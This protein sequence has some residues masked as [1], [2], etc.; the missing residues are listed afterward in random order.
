MKLKRKRNQNAPAR[1]RHAIVETLETRTFLSV[2]ASTNVLVFNASIPGYSGGGVA[3]PAETVTLTNTGS[4]AIIFSGGISVVADPSD[5][6]N[7][8]AQFAITNAG[9]LPG[10]LGA[11]QS[12]TVSVD[13]TASVANTIQKALLQIV[14]NDPANPD[15]LISLRGLGT[16]GFFGTAEPS[17]VNILRASNI[18]TIVGAGPNDSDASNSQYPEVPDTSSQEVPLQRLVKAGPGPVTIT[19]LASFNASNPTTVVFGYYTPGDPTDTTQLFTIAQADAQTVNP[20]LLGATSFDPGSGE[21]GLYATFPGVATGTSQPDTHYSEDP[22]NTLDTQYPRKFRFFPLKNADGSTVPNAY[23][24]AAEDYNS[25]TYNS[26]INFLGIIRNVA[27][28]PGAPS[29]AVLGLENLDLVPSTTQM[30]FNR[31]QNTNPTDP[32]GFVDTVHDTN[33]LEIINTGN[34]P[35]VISSVTLSD[36]TNWQITTPVAPNTTV[37]ANGGTLDITIKFI[38]TTDPPHTDN[39]TNDSQPANGLTVQQA[40]GVWDAT[41][42]IAANDLARPTRTVDLAGYWQN[43]S[44]N[45]NEPGLQTIVNRL[46]GYTTTI[47]SDYQP[48]FPA[49]SYGDEQIAPFWQAADSSLPVTV[50]ALDSWHTQF[51]TQGDPNSETA[52]YMAWYPMGTI[53]LN[54]LFTLQKGEGQS[55]LPTISGSNTQLA[56]ASFNPSGAFEWYMDG[57]SSND[58]ENNA[59]VP[60]G[61]SRHSIRAYPLRDANGNVVPN[62]WL[63]VEDYGGSSYEN[64][65]YQD[66]I[67]LVT[68]VTPYQFP[69]A[70][71]SIAATYAAS[72][73]TLQWA[74]SPSAGSI[75]YNVYRA[76]DNAG[77]YTLLTSSPT[78]ATS[79]LDT[80]APA[81][82]TLYYRV[83]VISSGNEGRGIGASIYTVGATADVL[84]SADIN[85]TPAGST[86]VLSPGLSYDIVAG[87]ADIGGTTADGFR[88]AYES[89]TGDFDAKVQVS[90]ISQ[91]VNT[92]SRAGLIVKDT[93]DPG[94]RMVFSGV[95]ADGSYRFNYR[96]TAN[97][98][99]TFNVTGS[100]TFPNSWVR[101]VRSGNTFTTYSSPDGSTWTETGTLTLALPST[102]YLGLAVAS[103]DPFQTVEAQLRNFAVAGPSI[104]VISPPTGLTAM[105][106]GGTIA[107]SWA[108]SSGAAGYNVFRS[109]SASGPFTQLNS[110]VITTTSYS[111]TTA[112]LNVTAYYEVTAVDGSG[113]TSAPATTSAANTNGG[114]VSFPTNLTATTSSTGITL[115]WT[116][117]SGAV[118]YNVLRSSS[119]SGPFSAVNTSSITTTTY[120]DTTAAPGQISYYEVVAID[121]M[122]NV[123]A[124]ATTSATRMQVST[125]VN[126][127]GRRVGT[128]IDDAGHKVT[129]RLAGPGTGVATFLSGSNDPSSITLANTTAGSIFTV[130]VAGAKAT[131]IGAI[132]DV[133]ALGRITATTTTLGDVTLGATLGLMQIASA[134]GQINA[135]SIN[136]LIVAST[137]SASLNLTG[138]GRDVNLATIRG[139][140]TGGDWTLAGSAGQITAPGVAS[141]WQGTF[142]GAVGL[143]IDRG[144]FAGTLIAA[145]AQNITITGSLTGS[146]QLTGVTTRDLGV[147]SVG[148]AINGGSVMAAGSIRSITA[149]ALV[150]ADV[151]AGVN[152]GV[153]TLPTSI[154]E[155]ASPQSITSVIITGRRQPFAVQGSNVA[156]ESLGAVSFGS[157]NTDNSG[158][159]FG[160]A[161]HTLNSYRRIIDGQ[162]LT[163]TRFKDPA[164]L[165]PAGDAVVNLV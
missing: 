44:E 6:S 43:T 92:G 10:S 151:F 2:S 142:G 53:N 138:A 9:S 39:Q 59:N 117:A 55:L 105:A 140:L 157:V 130:T 84:T 29:G 18:P 22:L 87:G 136:Q 145:T 74:P 12:I 124:P 15:V 111:D 21:F 109:S 4:T 65:D 41:L 56:V 160:L 72:G 149:A 100:S 114:S 137:L 30:V 112:P 26:F 83:T 108:A 50:Q 150:N 38:A 1:V 69:A 101:L 77:P 161:A 73:V 144:D 154:N 143:F 107:L 156:A 24:V 82:S 25:P 147:L 17:L 33:T 60:F 66:N 125:T 91:N 34:Q 104:P 40:G 71:E 89:V 86:T 158:T 97:A 28:A 122:G 139:G 54:G 163:W 146:I 115:Q 61:N 123:S 155:F 135:V 159:Q 57:E 132:N 164:L 70:P 98:T 32:M 79:Y 14:S 90:S 113:N 35:L 127:G 120:A 62:T 81:N 48:D 63:L 93:L 126:F 49:S 75:T 85:S 13:Y 152:A 78:S 119:A 106:S 95:A 96:T 116:A 88:F 99:G 94:S 141:G 128:Y 23:V 8:A 68:N 129:L 46:F 27:A 165:T 16:P 80:T 5:S 52:P 131:T 47:A 148:G 42:T 118:G 153:T 102:V 134:T 76:D 31:I 37:A 51:A 64:Y 3:S 162:V 58:A 11:G 103:H 67:L 133:N 20:T 36:T 45:E 7:E 110:G 121:G 19:P